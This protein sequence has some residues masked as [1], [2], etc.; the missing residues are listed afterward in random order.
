M[1]GY[2][3]VMKV[4]DLTPKSNSNCGGAWSHN[5]SKRKS[6]ELKTIL[7]VAKMKKLF[8]Y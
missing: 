7:T 5:W 2:G 3:N 8:P 6:Q 1:I 4:W